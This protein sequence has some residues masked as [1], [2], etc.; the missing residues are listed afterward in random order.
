[1]AKKS[2]EAGAWVEHEVP[3]LPAKGRNVN[4]EETPL[5]TGKVEKVTKASVRDPEGGGRRQKVAVTMSHEGETFVAWLPL[6]DV[7]YPMLVKL[8]GKLVQI[9]REGDASDPASVRYRVRSRAA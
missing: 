7:Y 9:E 1:M 6:P 5:V 2:S 8:R 4:W 3:E